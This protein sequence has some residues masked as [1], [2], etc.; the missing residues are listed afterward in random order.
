MKRKKHLAPILCAS[1]LGFL[2]LNSLSNQKD[3]ALNLGFET[4]LGSAVS[5]PDEDD[6]REGG[7]LRYKFFVKE[8]ESLSDLTTL[9]KQNQILAKYENR[10]NEP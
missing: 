8:K 7:L 3:K 4:V 2:A 9:R 1:L 5:Q 6:L 10:K